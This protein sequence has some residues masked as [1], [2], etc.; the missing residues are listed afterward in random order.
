MDRT[1][2][3]A[4]SRTCHALHSLTSSPALEAAWLWRWHGDQ[5]LFHQRSLRSMPVLRQLVEVHHADIN[6]LGA[7]VYGLGFSLL[8]IACQLD[9]TEL[10]EFLISAPRINMIN[11]NLK[12]G[13]EGVMPLHVAC[14]VWS[15]R[16]VRQLLA[17]PQIQVNAATTQGFSSLLY[18]CSGQKVEVVEELLRHPDIDVNLTAANVRPPLAMAANMGNSAIVALLL[19]HPAINVNAAPGVAGGPS[20]LYLASKKGHAHVVRQLLGHPD[21]HVN[22]VAGLTSLG[23][24]C[25]NEHLSVI[26]ELLLHPGLEASSIRAALAT[27]E[28]RGQTAVVALLKGRREA[29]R[30]RRGEGG[31]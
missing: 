18:A 4:L 14:M 22:G 20:P 27:A 7:D 8:H 10:V 19:Q 21:I 29:R 2:I 3:L 16:A 23:I 11:I 12:C 15:T 13:G 6:A 24:A 25:S 9:R 5:A 28:A 30:A 1:D 17:L 26:R 31:A